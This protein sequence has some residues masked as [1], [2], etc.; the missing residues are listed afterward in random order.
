[1]NLAVRIVPCKIFLCISKIPVNCGLLL[2]CYLLGLKV[3]FE[4]LNTDGNLTFWMELRTYLSLEQVG[5]YAKR[6]KELKLNS[7]EKAEGLSLQDLILN[8][9]AHL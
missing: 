9:M 7:M 6:G 4:V 5:E 1:M 8:W 2:F 3:V